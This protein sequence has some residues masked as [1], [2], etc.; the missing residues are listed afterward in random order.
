MKAAICNTGTAIPGN[1]L[2]V[3]EWSVSV[4]DYGNMFPLPLAAALSSRSSV[5]LQASSA[6]GILWTNS[7]DSSLATLS[8]VAPSYS[9]YTGG[10]KFRFNAPAGALTDYILFGVQTNGSIGVG[11]DLMTAV[12]TG[13]QIYT[14]NFGAA[15]A[16][17]PTVIE[18]FLSTA[19]SAQS[20][21]QT[22]SATARGPRRRPLGIQYFPV[23]APIGA[24]SEMINVQFDVPI[25]CEPSL[26]YGLCCRIPVGTATG[27]QVIHGSAFIEG[28]FL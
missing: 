23:G 28:Y 27:S 16:T 14:Y 6:A 2:D 12:L 1:Y 22:N 13:V 19:N 3:Y 26:W 15:V 20:L 8:N 10:G 11:V 24:T 17:T 21:A 5:H 4:A 25:V 9:G 18:W 7:N